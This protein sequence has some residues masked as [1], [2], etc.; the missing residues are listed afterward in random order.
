MNL[1][2]AIEGSRSEYLAWYA[3][4]TIGFCAPVPRQSD[5]FLSD[6]L[7]YLY[8]PRND[9]RVAP[10]GPAILVQVK[11]N[12]DDESFVEDRLATLRDLELPYFR[13]VI[14]REGMLLRVFQTRE[15][16]SYRY[17]N[18]DKLTLRLGEAPVGY[19]GQP[20]EGILYL[21]KPIAEIAIGDLEKPECRTHFFG[22][23]QKWAAID[24]QVIGLNLLDLPVSLSVNYETNSDPHPELLMR[25][26]HN[27]GVVNRATKGF[28]RVCHAQLGLL[29]LAT[30]Q[31][32]TGHDDA[33]RA[34]SALLDVLPE[35]EAQ[36]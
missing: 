26:H 25:V 19:K 14:D 31:G 3:L 18:Y 23:M 20:P 28:L 9:T 34:I 16:I 15:R 8:E 4:S 5:S 7:V 32:E 10:T 21:G 35:P 1:L 22:I 24:L 2:N 30:R 29:H 27:D 11:S 6:F 13:A 33:I 17:H 12:E 36:K